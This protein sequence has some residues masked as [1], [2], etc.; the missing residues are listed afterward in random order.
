M[1]RTATERV[2]DRVI[3]GRQ[4]FE[5]FHKLEGDACS[6]CHHRLEAC[7]T[8]GGPRC[9]CLAG[10][11]VKYVHWSAGRPLQLATEIMIRRGARRFGM[12]D[13]RGHCRVCHSAPHTVP[14]ERARCENIARDQEIAR[15][16]YLA[17]KFLQEV[18]S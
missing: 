18:A 15:K 5:E 11:E 3:L 9:Y 14:A 1:S 6:V 13:K 16:E 17:R 2:E 4:W 7:G 10:G 12:L 8:C